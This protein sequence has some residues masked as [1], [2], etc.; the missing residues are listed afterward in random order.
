MKCIQAPGD[1]VIYRV[2]GDQRVGY[3][4]WQEYEADG[5]PP[6]TRVTTAERDQYELVEYFEEEF[7]HI[8]QARTARM[9]MTRWGI[10]E[11][12]SRNELLA[13]S[14]ANCRGELYLE[15]GVLTGET[16]NIIASQVDATVYGF[17]SF[18]GLPENWGPGFRRG[19]FK[20]RSRPKL[21]G[22]VR[23]VVGWFEDVLPGFL[24]EHPGQVAFAHIDS[25]V[26]SSASYVLTTLADNG[27]LGEGTVLQFD[28]IFA[29]KGELWY[30]G[31][32][33][34]FREFCDAHR[35]VYD[36]LGYAGEAATLR[37]AS[38]GG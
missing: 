32:Y 22:D 26:Y 30:R 13:C 7:E 12:P 2:K 5:K 18:E 4:S 9:L 15:F 14:L 28:E 17:D 6:V 24:E 37:I 33:D 3:R 19:H 29:V 31:E 27:R 36:W 25:D 16:V 21:V 34:A 10:P 8:G 35:P 20:T 11:F 23:L 38:M 1:P